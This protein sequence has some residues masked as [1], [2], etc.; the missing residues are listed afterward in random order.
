MINWLII[1]HST[2]EE[3]YWL[4]DRSK[5][6]LKYNCDENNIHSN[7]KMPSFFPVDVVLSISATWMIQEL[8]NHWRMI[9]NPN[10]T[11][12]FVVSRSRTV[13]P[14]HGDLVLSGVSIRASLN[15]DILGVKFG[16][17][18]SHSKTMC[19]VLFPVP[20]LELLFSG[21]WNVYFWTSLCYFV[22]ILHLFSQS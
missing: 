4:N 10:K 7:N 22:A 13:R 3:L 16:S 8:C 17:T 20:L 11:K 5:L 21:W 15:I 12:A 2:S 19:V 6:F 14:P 9:L 18:W 1:K